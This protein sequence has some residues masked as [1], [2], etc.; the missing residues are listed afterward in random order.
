MTTNIEALRKA[1][2]AMS[3]GTFR[4]SDFPGWGP[5]VGPYIAAAATAA[6]ELLAEVDRLK[7]ERDALRA[8]AVRYQVLRDEGAA[9]GLRSIFQL[10][11][12]EWDEAIDCSTKEQA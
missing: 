4:D 1:M 2:P 3:A 12:G 9:R 6:P 11:P 7:A 10:M 5:V 8:D